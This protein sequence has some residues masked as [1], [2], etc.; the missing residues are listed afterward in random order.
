M[1]SGLER[2]DLARMFELAEALEAP[3][4]R[5]ALTGVLCGNRATSDPPW[6]ER[7]RGVRERLGRAA[8]M[9]ERAGRTVVIENHQDFTSSELAGFCEEFGPTVRVVY[10]TGNS[11]PVGEAPLDFTRVVAPYVAYVHLKDYRVQRTG[12]GIRLVRCAIGD[13]AVPLRELIECLGQRHAELPAVLEPGALEVRHV[14]FFT[15]GWW[16]GYPPREARAL[17]RCI[18][19]T[20]PNALS[21]DADWRTPWEHGEDDRVETYELDMIRRSA[22]NMR[23]LGIM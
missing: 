1:S 21:A 2:G 11:F 9:A 18:A 6:P 14:R 10:D 22:A 13:G 12:E 3:L 5:F 23:A 7:V 20:L 17:A 4:L 8:E 16:V 15:D 19:A